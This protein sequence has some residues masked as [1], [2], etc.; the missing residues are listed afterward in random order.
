MIDR[1]KF[2]GLCLLA[3]ACS[4]TASRPIQEMADTDAA[5]RAAREV[6]ALSLAPEL[7]RQANEN[8]EKAKREYR[9]KNFQQ[10]KA[11]AQIARDF[12]E[13]AEYEAIRAGG[14]RASIPEDPLMDFSLPDTE[15]SDENPTP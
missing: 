11:L 1:S 3:S 5:V 7:F 4:V 6:N 8:H 15:S 2:L 13:R 10:A 12:A 14:E 9:V